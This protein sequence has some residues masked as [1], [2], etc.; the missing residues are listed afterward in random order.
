MT[1]KNKKRGKSKNR[2]TDTQSTDKRKKN[3]ED[4]TE[5]K[6]LNITEDKINSAKRSN[7]ST[8]TNRVLL[9][10]LCN[11]LGDGRIVVDLNLKTGRKRINIAATTQHV[12][13]SES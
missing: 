3:T 8:E 11:G 5:N 9:D 2:T 7:S 1:Q 4:V 6:Q 10:A 13:A 12:K